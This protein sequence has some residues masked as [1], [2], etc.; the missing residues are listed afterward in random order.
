[1]RRGVDG[2]S[3]LFIEVS[4]MRDGEPVEVAAVRGRLDRELVQLGLYDCHTVANTIFPSNLWA[5]CG[6]RHELYARY[7]RMLPRL[8]RRPPIGISTRRPDGTKRTLPG[9]RRG[10][11]IPSGWDA[12]SEP[13]LLVEGPSD[14]LAC[15]LAGLPCVGRPSNLGGVDLLV[16][17]LP[18]VAAE[19]PVIVVGENDRKD[20]GAWPGLAGAVAVA[21]QLGK[22][23]RRPIR[24][25]MPPEGSKDVRAWFIAGEQGEL[26]WVSRGFKILYHLTETARTVGPRSGAAAS[27]P[28]QPGPWYVPIPE[29]R[30][31][32]T[33][34]LP[35]PWTAF[36]RQGAASL[37]CDEALVA[38]PLLS[39]LAAA[40]GNNR[41]V[42]LGGEW[43][44][45]SVLWTCA[46]SESGGL[47]SP[48]ADLS[49]NQVKALESAWSRSTRTLKRSARPSWRPS[50]RRARRRPRPGWD[51]TR[52]PVPQ[53]MEVLRNAD[54]D[55]IERLRAAAEAIR[56]VWRRDL[57]PITRQGFLFALLTGMRSAS[58]IG[59]L[60]RGVP[61]LFGIDVLSAYDVSNL[62]AL[63]L[64]TGSGFLTR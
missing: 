33:H 25:A 37:K 30:P 45:P 56:A 39:V 50:S 53:V 57:T 1:M 58:L 40:I 34:C 6:D 19:R 2:V 64:R 10:L 63:W 29:Y 32:P 15:T 42:Y 36:V 46:V 61:G 26:P 54:I 62:I 18:R 11:T 38:L 23:L 52:W 55:P 17:L 59:R 41:R 48:A 35:G 51:T 4:G 60:R 7:R 8:L 27:S 13:V 47:K 9:S 31:F 44:E 20:D 12:G 21:E 28:S 22:Q 43:F 14:V 5:R 24:W 16:G 3:P 49:I